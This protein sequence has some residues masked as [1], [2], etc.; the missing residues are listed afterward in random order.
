MVDRPKVCFGSLSLGQPFQGKRRGADV[1]NRRPFLKSNLKRLLTVG[2]LKS[3][4]LAECGALLV[5]AVL[6]KASS[7]GIALTH[8]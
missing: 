1:A 3:H 5:I 7:D 2:N 6:S 4:S 8:E